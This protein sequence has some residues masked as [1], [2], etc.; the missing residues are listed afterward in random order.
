MQASAFPSCKVVE[1]I[2][3]VRDTEVSDAEGVKILVK[4]YI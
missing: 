3:G 1:S 2:W 4:L